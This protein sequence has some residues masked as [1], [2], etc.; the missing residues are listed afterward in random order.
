MAVPTVVF[1]VAL[2]IAIPVQAAPPG[3]PSVFYGT[4]SVSPSIPNGSN[5]VAF[6][7]GAE[8][9]RTD[10][11]YD[12]VKGSVYVLDVRAD[13]P[14]TP[15]REGGRNGDRLTFAVHLATGGQVSMAQGATWQS[16]VPLQLDLSQNA[17]IFVPLILRR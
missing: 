4:V 15:E 14:D 5:V 9:G 6:I 8:Y 13:N 17:S 1:A 2:L 11:R 3:L 12:A 16:G 7:N 10:I